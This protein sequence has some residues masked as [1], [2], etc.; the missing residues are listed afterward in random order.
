M[1]KGLERKAAKEDREDQKSA[2]QYMELQNI[3][4]NVQKFEESS[5]EEQ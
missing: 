1:K 5:E 2:A 3:F 4:K